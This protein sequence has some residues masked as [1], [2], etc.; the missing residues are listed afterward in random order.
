M[1]RKKDN[2]Q[3]V[4][5]INNS[6][7]PLTP[8]YEGLEHYR[9][10]NNNMLVYVNGDLVTPLCYGVIA[11]TSEI[12]RVNGFENE[13][14]FEIIA[15]NYKGDL[16]PRIRVNASDFNSLNWVIKNYG[17]NLAITSGQTV[18]QKLLTGIQL[19]GLNCSRERVYT[20]TGYLMRDNKPVDYLHFGGDLLGDKAIRTDIN[21]SLFRYEML[22]PGDDLENKQAI[23]ASLQLLDIQEKSVTY[24]LLAFTYLSAISPIIRTVCGVMGFG[25]YLQGKTQSGKSTLAGLICSH[26]G[27]FTATTP[28]V[29]FNATSNAIRELSFILKDMPLWIDDFI[30][31]SNKNEQTKQN[32]VMQDIARAIGDN[33]TRLKLN[34]DSSIKAIHPPRCNYI[35]TGEDNADIGQSGIARLYTLNISGQYKSGLINDLL[36]SANKGLLSRSMSCYIQ[37]VINHYDL[38][39]I[40]FENEYNKVLQDCITK[41]GYCRLATQTAVLISSLYCLLYFVRHTGVITSDKAKELYQTGINYILQVSDSNEKQISDNDPVKQFMIIISDVLTTGQKYLIN[42]NN[43]KFDNWSLSDDIIGY[44]DENYIYL[45]GNLAYKTIATII[46]SQNSYFSISKTTL[47]KQLLEKGYILSSDKNPQTVKNIRGQSVRVLK[48]NRKQLLEFSNSGGD[49]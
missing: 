10:T 3:P 32:N 38:M 18:K 33:S 9:I 26:F 36:S 7:N 41:F 16:L 48:F 46:Q 34:S 29:S 28:P 45:N 12:T 5:L 11:I 1:T 42:L 21:N 20:H 14:V 23:T 39:L 35:I 4:N 49:L 22:L 19:T 37:F 13:I 40:T 17:C 27:K 44:C 31:R 6:S 8:Y 43:N 30:P 24:P 25:I 15:T 2:K 47:Y